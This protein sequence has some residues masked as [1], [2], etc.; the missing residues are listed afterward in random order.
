MNMK[1]SFLSWPGLILLLIST[2]TLAAVP[3]VEIYSPNTENQY[4]GLQLTGS[5]ESYHHASLAPLQA[6]MVQE[7]HVDAGAQVKQGQVL[8][9]L[10]DTLAGIQLQQAQSALVAANVEQQEAQRLY[11]EVIRLSKQKL[12]EQTLIGQRQAGLNKA[13]AEHSRL[14]AGLALAQEILSRHTLKA[15]FSGVIASRQVAPG[16]WITPQSKAFELVDNTRLRV[17]VQIPQEYLARFRDDI[18]HIAVTPDTASAEPVSAGHLTLVPVSNP[19]TRTFT[20]LIALPHADRLIAGSSARVSISLPN[21]Q[22]QII[23]LPESAVKQHPDGGSSVFVVSSD[24]TLERKV[25]NIKQHKGTQVAISQLP[26]A[27]SYV[28]KGV[29]K[30]KTGLKVNPKPVQELQP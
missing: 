15:P 16:E 26:G 23:W 28:V 5:I 7:I 11:D 1:Q 4:T 14:K 30:L 20:G 6:G 29:E 24:N 27:L 17:R 12:V 10:N 25:V 22:Q 3:E 8:L 18:S 21:S 19:D 13:R 2:S 9:S